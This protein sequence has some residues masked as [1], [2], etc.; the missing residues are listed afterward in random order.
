MSGML[1][2]KGFRV[3]VSK[4]NICWYIKIYNPDGIY[5]TKLTIFFL[6]CQQFGVSITEE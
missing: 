2:Y 4:I 3:K 1:Y 6:S 5:Q